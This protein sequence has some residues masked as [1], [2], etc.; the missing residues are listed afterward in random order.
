[1]NYIIGA[2]G[3]GSWLMPAL[4]ML[5]GN[6]NNIT[7]VDKDMLEGRNL[8]RQLF[9]EADIG[10]SKAE[11]LCARYGGIPIPEW[12]TSGSLPIDEGD[13]LFVCA[14]NHRARLE[15][16]EEC[17]HRGCV[18]II[19]GNETTSAEAYYYQPGWRKS[20]LDP[21][22]YYPEITTD[23]SGDPI[24]AGIGCTGEAQVQT[25]QL[26]CANFMAVALQQSLYLCWV[27]EIHKYDKEARQHLP[28]KLISNLT[29]LFSFKVKDATEKEAKHE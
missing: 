1:M 10:M 15:A 27:W 20:P 2:G 16:I 28:Y 29:R 23:K 21:R 25:P 3:G 18:A 22:V 4:T 9:T 26:V 7:V 12:F 5:T 14:D 8:N 13:V 24:A 6:S 19:A 17:D 11:A